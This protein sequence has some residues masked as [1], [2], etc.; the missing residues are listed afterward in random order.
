MIHRSDTVPLISSSISFSLA[1][2]KELLRW[3]N[4]KAITIYGF[5]ERNE[6]MKKKEKKRKNRNPTILSFNNCSSVSRECVFFV[7][8]CARRLSPLLIKWTMYEKTRFGHE[9]HTTLTQKTKVTENQID[10]DHMNNF[11]RKSNNVY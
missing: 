9:N 4:S 10:I 8:F 2:P 1:M 6:F 3:K 11:L 5:N 7:S